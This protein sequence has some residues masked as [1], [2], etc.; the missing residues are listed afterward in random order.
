[1]ALS[2][3]KLVVLLCLLLA[4]VTLAVYNPVVRNQFVDFDDQAYIL[5]NS[6]IQ[7]GLNWALVKWSVT[8]FYYGIWHP[9]T[10]LSHA[11][12]YQL[13]HLNPV[14]HHYTSVLLHAINAVLLF[15][16]LRRATGAIWPSIFVGALFA[17][18]PINV[19]SLAWAAE[20][21][22][23]LSTLFFLLALHAYDRYA[24]TFRKYLY[25][26][27]ILFFALG[28]MAKPQIVTLPFVLLLWDYWPLQRIGRASAGTSLPENSGSQTFKSLVLEKWPLF[29][30]AL[31]DSV[32]TLFSQRAGNTIRSLSEVPLGIRLENVFLSYVKY[33]GKA[34]WPSHLVPL[35]PRPESL[36]PLWQ[37]AGAIFV[38]LLITALVLYRRHDRYL[39]VGWFW[40]LGC[41]VPMIGLVTVGDQA[42]ADRYAYVAFIGLFIA[43]AWSF[44]DLDWKSDQHKLWMGAPAAITLAVFAILSYRQVGFWHDSETL[45]RYTLSVTEGNYVAHNNLALA[46]SEAG[47]SD[48]AVREFRAGMALHPYPPAQVVALALYEL[49]V[50]HPHEAIEECH[51]ALRLATDNATKAAA[52][53]ELGQADLQLG[54]YAA[55]SENFEQALR[56]Q[57][58]NGMALMGTGLMAL[59]QKQY[60]LAVERLMHAAKVDPSDMNALLLA[61]A[62]RRAG[63]NRDADFV[64]AQVRKISPNL[65]QAQMATGRVLS[66]AGLNPI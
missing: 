30:L 48:E 56:I 18:H 52:L 14:G 44:H 7:S 20:R 10:W 40:F 33:L 53:S 42:M 6:H 13:F 47:K 19:E 31:A 38:I 41:L 2:R 24:G 61:E 28:L 35:Y 26:L 57:P 64:A 49:Q 55:A 32:V 12:D 46:L 11:L 21:K 37:A 36:A 3:Q 66:F 25:G 43:I 54:D 1:M 16:L 5:K 4:A 23:V 51:L 59:H 27:V 22:N 29:L 65:V 62:L 63:R 8:T 50:E 45:W 9:L 39:L 60:D 17:L 58:A 34:F 15:L